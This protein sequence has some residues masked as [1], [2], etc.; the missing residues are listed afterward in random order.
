M[1][2]TGIVAKQTNKTKHYSENARRY[3]FYPLHNINL[4]GSQSTSP[5]WN[6]HILKGRFML[7]EPC[8]YITQ[9]I[10]GESQHNGIQL[11]ERVMGT[12]A[13]VAFLMGDSAGSGF[14]EKG[15]TY[16]SSLTDM[17]PNIATEIEELVLP[18]KDGAVYIPNSLLEFRDLVAKKNYK[19]S[20]LAEKAEEVRA[21]VL[22]GIDTS[23]AYCNSFINTV[24]SEITNARLGKHGL[25]NITANHKYYY[26][27]INKPYL[28]DREGVNS[29]N[30]IANALAPLVNLINK[31]ATDDSGDELI[32]L[33]SQVE[34]LKTRL[35]D[36]EKERDGLK[37][38]IENE[39]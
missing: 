7:L 20:P 24:E 14:M 38:L 23:I 5:V 9:V 3:I 35:K 29:G 2:T 27:A 10:D 30:Q 21:E 36:T 25:M 16:L 31:S 32:D 1:S 12:D 18:S 26:D 17:N 37:T 19:D 33:K 34:L 4:S 22:K 8:E 28:D 39:E 11:G 6:P 13:Q 15:M